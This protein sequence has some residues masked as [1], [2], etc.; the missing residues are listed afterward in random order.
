MPLI[1]HSEDRDDLQQK[2]SDIWARRNDRY[3]EER[4]QPGHDQEKVE[5]YRLGG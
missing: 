5:M 3:S 2:V 1:R 4:G